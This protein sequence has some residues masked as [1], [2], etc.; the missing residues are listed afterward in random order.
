MNK[1]GCN[2]IQKGGELWMQGLCNECGSEIIACSWDCSLEICQNC[3]R[4]LV[5]YEV[6]DLGEIV[7]NS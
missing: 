3:K 4:D 1:C 7:K 5:I 6:L 2:K